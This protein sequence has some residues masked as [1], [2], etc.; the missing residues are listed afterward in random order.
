M[1]E[2]VGVFVQGIFGVGGERTG[3]LEMVTSS[4]K[5]P[6]TADLVKPEHKGK[7]IVGGSF[8]EADALRKA[9]KIGV[10]GIVVGGIDD[11]DLRDYL[12]YDIG[13]AI[14]GGEDIPLTLIVTEGFGEI[15]MAENT[16][17]LL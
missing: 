6:L 12:G 3:E 11:R 2:A 16:F 17:N 7:V 13:V 10:N 14:T 1:V 8:V 9:G 4:H 5:E 15:P